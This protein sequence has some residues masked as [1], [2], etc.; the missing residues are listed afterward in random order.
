MCLNETFSEVTCLMQNGLEHGDALSSSLFTFA[1]EYV[2]TQI[3]E[4]EMGLKLYGTH[5]QLV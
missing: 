3:Q 1:L 2:I 4:F 5:E